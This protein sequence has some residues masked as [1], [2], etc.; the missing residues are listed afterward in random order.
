MMP[1]LV[2]DVWVVVLSVGRVVSEKGGKV[3]VNGKQQQAAGCWV[4]GIARRASKTE[5]KLVSG[6][7]WI[8]KPVQDRE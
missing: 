5:K 6:Q 8:A 4:V 1:V 2:G 7:T 3:L